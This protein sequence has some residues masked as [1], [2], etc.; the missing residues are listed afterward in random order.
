MLLPSAL[1]SQGIKPTGDPKGAVYISWHDMTQE[2]YFALHLLLGG[3]KEFVEQRMTLTDNNPVRRKKLVSEFFKTTGTKLNQYKTSMPIIIVPPVNVQNP[4]YFDDGSG[5]SISLP[6]K[7]LFFAQEH[8]QPLTYSLGY[9]SPLTPG[10]TLDAKYFNSGACCGGSSLAEDYLRDRFG[11]SSWMN[12]RI[13]TNDSKN[14]EAL[15]DIAQDPFA[16]YASEQ[17]TPAAVIN[18]WGE[19]VYCVVREVNLFFRQA[20]GGLAPILN[21]HWNGDDFDVTWLDFALN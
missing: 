3:T 11:F 19:E 12:V 20:S 13:K 8:S 1:F 17:C 18:I 5:F 21:L 4:T 14:L 9:P 16:L 7:T 2:D 15:F 6:L 10:A